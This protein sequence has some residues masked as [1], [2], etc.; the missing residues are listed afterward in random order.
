MSRSR[1]K[2]PIL[3]ITTAASEKSDKQAAN[4]KF[5]RI[6]K[7]EVNAEEDVITK[8]RE[9]SDIWS[10]AKDGKRFR[11]NPANRDLRK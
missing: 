2:T 10:F 4:R 7:Q 11:K 8:K 9:A 3:G 1:K 6:V 5:R